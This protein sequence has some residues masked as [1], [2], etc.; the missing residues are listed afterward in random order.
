MLFTLRRKRLFMV[1][2]ETVQ[3]PRRDFVQKERQPKQVE[4]CSEAA[5]KNPTPQTLVGLAG[6]ADPER[7]AVPASTSSS[8]HLRSFASRMSEVRRLR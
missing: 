8:R 7:V 4:G 5:N 6:A 1:F 3:R 2:C